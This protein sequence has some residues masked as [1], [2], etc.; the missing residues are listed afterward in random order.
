MNA[1]LA[2]GIRN[3]RLSWTSTTLV[4]IN[5]GAA[6]VLG[7]ALIGFGSISSAWAYLHGD[8]L[9]VDDYS[10]S[11][12][13]VEQGQRPTVSFQV[14]N[15]YEQPVMIMGV[16]TPC[17]FVR[18]SDLPTIVPAHATRA[19][20][21][22]VYTRRKSGDI[23]VPLRLL[24]NAPG[25]VKITLRVGGRVSGSVSGTGSSGSNSG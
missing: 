7:W 13:V 23:S 6:A 25:H 17:G 18:V 14:T 20:R 19:V 3:I 22:I 12:G 24:T 16:E 11:F 1:A 9:I 2:T 4:F 10:K 21:F 5:V 8:R 15:C